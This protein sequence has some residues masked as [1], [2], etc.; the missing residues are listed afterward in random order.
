ME[1]YEVRR[2]IAADPSAIWRVLT[3]GGA[4]VA[5]GTG[6]ARVD[7]PIEA[8]SRFTIYSDAVPGRGFR[9]RVT[10]FGPPQSMEWTGGLPAGLFRGVRRFSLSPADGG[11]DFHMREEF[12]G[13]M[14]ALIW[15][16]MP[17]LQPSFEQFADGVAR[18]AE[19]D[20]EDAR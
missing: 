11:T 3:D 17:D 1:F 15:R 6:V 19:G 18:A 7:G 8:G 14:L 2:R 12:T 10:A 4:L 13:P 9:T 5:A 20:R 16:S